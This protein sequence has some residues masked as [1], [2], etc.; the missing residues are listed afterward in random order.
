MLTE[1]KLHGQLGE[2]VG[3]LW[4]AKVYSVSEALRAVEV[5]SKHKLFKYLADKERAGLKYQVL[6]NGRDFE[7]GEFNEEHPETVFKSELVAKNTNIKTIDIIPVIEGSDDLLNLIL[8]VILIVVGYFTGAYG[9][10]YIGVGLLAAGVA[11]LLAQPPEFEEFK[12]LGKTSYLFNGPENT[13]GEGGPVP[14]VYGRL[15]IGS[16]AIAA[17]YQNLY[18]DI[19]TNQSVLTVNE[20]PYFSSSYT[21]NAGIGN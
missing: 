13:V 20:R 1:I 14:V 4:K 6:I 2:K 21:I 17:N 8:G 3:K 19:D 9:L 5:N 11:G 18:M 16:L 10:I 12:P 15:I 7:K